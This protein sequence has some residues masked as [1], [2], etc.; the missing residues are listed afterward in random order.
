[1]RFIFSTALLGLAASGQAWA[2]CAGD[3][4]V[5]DFSITQNAGVWT[6]DFLVQN[7]CRPNAQPLLTDFF[8]PYFSDAGI[9]NITVPAP[10]NSALPS[11]TW[12]YSIQPNKT[13]FSV[14]ARE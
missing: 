12:T 13:M 10:D 14:W 11:I 8:I 9:S 1:V 7:G 2:I 3:T 6:Y 5:T 4:S